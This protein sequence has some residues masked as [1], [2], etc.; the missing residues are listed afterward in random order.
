MA[1]AATKLPVTTEKNTVPATRKPLSHIETLRR[2]ID[3]LF[4][5]LRPC[6]WQMPTT[7]S[8]FSDNMPSLR[9]QQ[10]SPSI[11][12]VEVNAYELTVELPGLDVADVD[13]TVSEGMLAIKGEK[14]DEKQ[15]REGDY[16]ISERQYGSFQGMLKLPDGVDA[17]KI[18]AN[19]A[20]GVLTINFPSLPPRG[21]PKRRSRSRNEGLIFALRAPAGARP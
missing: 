12:F 16:Y 14:K 2:E 20:K 1:D 9:D 3:R 6:A 4:D 5:E 19:F 8:L 17:D 15:K 13:V 18:A 10:I 7:C 11:H 21:R